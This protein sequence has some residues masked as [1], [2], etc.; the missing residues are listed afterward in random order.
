MAAVARRPHAGSSSLPPAS[1]LAAAG[2]DIRTAWAH[3]LLARAVDDEAA[4]LRRSAAD[5]A[6]RQVADEYAALAEGA[7][8][9]A[10]EMRGLA[11]G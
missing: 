9:F 4:S 3:W 10:D 1:Q 6:T 2:P 8:S 7:R 11:V 5:A